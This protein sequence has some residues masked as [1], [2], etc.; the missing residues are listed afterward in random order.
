[1]IAATVYILCSLT[2]I[3][4][5]VLLWK[6][7]RS[8]GVRLLFWSGICFLLLVVN[9]IFLVIDLAIIREI[10]F[11]LARVISSLLGACILIWA[12]IW[13]TV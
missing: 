12:F 11:S 1:M 5:T 2:S 3:L 7:Y 8:S 9:N 13:D 6:K 10:D 4:C